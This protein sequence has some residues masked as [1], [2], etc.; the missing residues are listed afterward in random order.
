MLGIDLFSGII[1]AFFLVFFIYAFSFL[2]SRFL[3]PKP[4][5]DGPY[6]LESTD[7]FIRAIESMRNNDIAF[8][9][10]EAS[11]KRHRTKKDPPHGGEHIIENYWELAFQPKTKEKEILRNLNRGR[12][13]NQRGE[14]VGLEQIDSTG[15]VTDYLRLKIGCSKTIKIHPLKSSNVIYSVVESNFLDTSSGNMIMFIDRAGD[16]IR[17]CFVNV[18]KGDSIVYQEFLKKF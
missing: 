12:F 2:R 1:G 13:I 11:I 16:I 6:G 10:F 4:N 14:E 5:F 9:L 17:L 3:L 15:L 8:A 18:A 7:K